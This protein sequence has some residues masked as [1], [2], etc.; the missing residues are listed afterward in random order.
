[1]ILY[2]V[3]FGL[4]RCFEDVFKRLRLKVKYFMAFVFDEKYSITVTLY[5][6]VH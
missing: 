1:M 2:A 5:N 3:I 6:K 4:L